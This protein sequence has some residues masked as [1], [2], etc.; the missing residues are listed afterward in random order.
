MGLLIFVGGFIFAL[1]SDPKQRNSKLNFNQFCLNQKYYV[2]EILGKDL[3]EFST[4]V[5]DLKDQIQVLDSKFENMNSK[6]ET[7]D[8]N[9]EDPDSK[10]E[11]RLVVLE[12]QV[13]NI[14]GRLS[15]LEMELNRKTTRPSTATTGEL[16][17]LK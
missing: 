14:T 10:L 1:S 16:D 11:D 8:S 13:K 2:S 12:T 7:I 3:K 9:S 4:Q 15:V 17:T 5:D 6:F